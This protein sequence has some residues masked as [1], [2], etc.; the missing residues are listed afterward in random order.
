MYLCARDLNKPKYQ[1]LIKKRKDVGI[2]HLNDSKA[3][4]QYPNTMDDVYNHINDY[5]LSKKKKN[6]DCV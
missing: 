2:K 3:F 5:N 4:L 6:L 1:F